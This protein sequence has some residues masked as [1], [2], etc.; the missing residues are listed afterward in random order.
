M[1]DEDTGAQL[2]ASKGT[3]PAG[4]PL[5]ALPDPFEAL[6]ALGELGYTLELEAL[7]DRDAVLCAPRPERVGPSFAEL[8]EVR[9]RIRA[10]PSSQPC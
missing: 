3:W 5:A 2:R 1:V 8:V 10:H 6:D 7:I 4:A 9:D